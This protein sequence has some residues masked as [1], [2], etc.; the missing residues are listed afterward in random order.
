MCPDRCIAFL[1][2]AACFHLA[3]CE[4]ELVILRMEFMRLQAW[5]RYNIELVT[6]SLGQ[7]A[8]VQHEQGGQ[9]LEQEQEQQPMQHSTQLLHPRT[10]LRVCDV[11]I[12]HKHATFDD[13]CVCLRKKRL[14][15]LH[16]MQDECKVAAHQQ[17]KFL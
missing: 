16:F 11:L 14:K 17:M 7:Q 10:A 9:P 13:A 2:T 6:R 3:R 5:L 12:R 1:R 4:E 15:R 8:E